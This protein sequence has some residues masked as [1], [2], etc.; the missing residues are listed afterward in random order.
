MFNALVFYWRNL[1]EI[2][3]IEFLC[4]STS[5]KGCRFEVFDMFHAAF[6]IYVILYKT[7]GCPLITD[8]KSHLQ[9]CERSEGNKSYQ[10]NLV[11]HSIKFRAV[12][13]T[14]S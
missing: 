12:I 2:K 4:T 10:I 11:S 5:D 13:K 14:S 1:Q 3:R 7:S 6:S 9:E 8:S